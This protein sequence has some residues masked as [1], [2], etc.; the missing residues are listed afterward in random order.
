[1]TKQDTPAKKSLWL[2]LTY[3][4][5]AIINWIYRNLNLY[6]AQWMVIYFELPWNSSI[7]TITMVLWI[8]SYCSMVLW[9]QQWRVCGEH[10]HIV[11]S[12]DDLAKVIE[13]CTNALHLLDS[14]SI[15]TRFLWTSYVD[16][17]KSI[18]SYMDGRGRRGGSSLHISMHTSTPC[19]IDVQLKM[20]S[21]WKIIA[22]AVQEW[23]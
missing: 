5:H 4:I 13:T 10:Q 19:I 15:W 18:F 20:L 2:L 9:S 7:C 22:F 1:M 14:V 11:Q 23:S 21:A 12:H 17:F 8:A 16:D 6:F 3:H